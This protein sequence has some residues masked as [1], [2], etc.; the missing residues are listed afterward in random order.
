[1]QPDLSLAHAILGDI[2]C[3]RRLYEAGRKHYD[4]A[5]QGNMVGVDAAE[6]QK[7]RAACVSPHP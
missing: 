4:N 3:E 2:S 1:M 6:I 5:L 7:R